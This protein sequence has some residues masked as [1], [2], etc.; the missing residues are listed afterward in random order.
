MKIKDTFNIIRGFYTDFSREQAEHL[1]DDLGLNPNEQ[2][3]IY[4]KETKKKF[5]LF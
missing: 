5:N 3:K 1:L 2:L 4:L